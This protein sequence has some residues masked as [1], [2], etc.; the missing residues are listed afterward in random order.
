MKIIIVGATGTIGRA[1]VNL[2]ESKHEVIKASRGGDVRVD[3]SNPVS[4]KEMYGEV[5]DIDAVICAA[6]DARFGPLDSFS[7]EDFQFSLGSKLMGQVNLVRF[8][9]EHINDGGVFTLTT[10]V[11]AHSPDAATVILT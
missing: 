2:F 10:G 11:L 7:D 1:I 3:L 4:I 8:G 5:S 6:G 9:R